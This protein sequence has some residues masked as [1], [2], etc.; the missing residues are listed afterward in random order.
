MS[1]NKKITVTLFFFIILIFVGILALKY[2]DDHS[3]RTGIT[4]DFKV[5][6]S[7]NK[8]VRLS[9]FKG[10]KPVMVFFAASWCTYCK[11]EMPD[12]QKLYEK[13]GSKVQ[14]MIIDAVGASGETRADFEKL[15]SASGYT[16]PVYYDE[17][18]I[19]QASFSVSSFPQ[20]FPVS[21][22]GKI[23]D[24]IIGASGYASLENSIKSLI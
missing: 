21:K 2:V 20:T 7:E 5:T 16:F 1:R 24:V 10:K 12:I 8:T 22:D 11:E 14:F 13:Y 4:K 3:A 6:S 19:A 17:G 9:D 15:V 18:Q 23:Q